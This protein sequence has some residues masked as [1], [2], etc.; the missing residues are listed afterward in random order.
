MY[1]PAG[2]ITVEARKQKLT[3]FLKLYMVHNKV[4]MKNSSYSPT[5]IVGAV[6]LNTR[7][8]YQSKLTHYTQSKIYLCH[9]HYSIT[10][11][12][13]CFELHASVARI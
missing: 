12:T 8:I 1:K 2:P 6:P 13:T 3:A 4:D 7:Y 5:S 11:I 10:T 9:R